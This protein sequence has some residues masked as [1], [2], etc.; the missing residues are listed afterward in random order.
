MYEIKQKLK[1]G[2]LVIG[3]MVSEL[4][5]PNVVHMLAQCGFD[6]IILDTEH[7]AY[8]PE[9]VS[10]MIAA[11]RGAAIPLV[12]RIP[13]IRRE[14]ILKPLDSGAAGL[15]VP[16]VNTVD[17]AQ[18]VINHAKYPPF[19]NRGVGLRRAHSL[20]RKVVAADYLSQA[21]ADT[22]IAVQAETTTAIDNLEA[23]ASVAGVDSIFV[24]PMDLSV[25]LG[26]P[27]QV[28]HPDEVAAIDRVIAVCQ[29]RNIAPGIMMFDVPTLKAWINKGMRF[30][31][32][33]SD[34]S[35]LA[36]IAVDGVKALKSATS[37]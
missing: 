18:A 9:A 5:N 30:V 12:V 33:S 7:G 13:E 19:G 4:R 22:F 25:S 36:D 32:Y 37:T 35:L 8:S 11:A 16:Q 24:G 1:Q 27:A 15:L 10:D 21:N 2:E 31:V 23:I 29:K 26:I 20:Y 34:I 6:F 17:Q 14:T 28:T 3:T